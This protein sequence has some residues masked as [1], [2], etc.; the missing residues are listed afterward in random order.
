MKKISWL[1]ISDCHLTNLDKWESQGVLNALI[2]DVERF[3]KKN[4]MLLDFVFITGDLT[5]SG[6]KEE[7]EFFGRF[8]EKLSSVSKVNKERVYIV[9]GNHDYEINLQ[10]DNIKGLQVDAEKSLMD[11]KIARIF[12]KESESGFLDD[13]FKPSE[14][15]NLFIERSTAI[16]RKKNALYYTANITAKNDLPNVSII[17]FN[18]AF[19]GSHYGLL[20]RFQVNEALNEIEQEI[21]NGNIIIG[22]SHHPL[23][24]LY[25]KDKDALGKLV[26]NKLDFLLSGHVHQTEILGGTYS[27]CTEIR[28]RTSYDKKESHHQYGYCFVELDFDEMKG[29]AIFRVFSDAKGEFVQDSELASGDGMAVGIKE[30]Q[31]PNREIEMPTL[32]QEVFSHIEKQEKSLLEKKSPILPKII[33][34]KDIYYSKN[35]ALALFQNIYNIKVSEIAFVSQDILSDLKTQIEKR[36]NI[37]IVLTGPAGSGK[38]TLARLVYLRI[39]NECKRNCNIFPIYLDLRLS[40]ETDTIETLEKIV[41]PWNSLIEQMVFFIDSFDEF[42]TNNLHSGKIDKVVSNLKKLSSNKIA[43]FSIRDKFFEINHESI[44]SLFDSN[45]HIQLRPWCVDTQRDIISSFIRNYLAFINPTVSKRDL[46]STVDRAIETM[47]KSGFDFVPLYTIMFACVIHRSNGIRTMESRYSLYYQFV[48]EML[49][50]QGKDEQERADEIF[51]TSREA[52]KIYL[53]KVIDIKGTVKRER[54]EVFEGGLDIFFDKSHGKGESF[55]H[56][57]FFQFFVATYV[58]D[59]F[60]NRATDN[61]LSE[62]LSIIHTS[63][64]N[65]LSKGYIDMILNQ[66]ENLNSSKNYLEICEVTKNLESAFLSAQDKDYQIKNEIVYFLGR[67]SNKF[68]CD[69]LQKLYMKYEEKLNTIF[70]EYKT[71]PLIIRQWLMIFRTLSISL[72]KQGSKKAEE[73]YLNRL[74]NSRI[75]DDVNRGIHLEYYQDIEYEKR[76][77]FPHTDPEGS[78]VRW[79]KTFARL[80]KHILDICHEAANPYSHN[81]ESVLCNLYLFTIHSFVRDRFQRN[82]DRL[83]QENIEALAFL[84]VIE[85]II[86]D[87]MESC[88]LVINKYLFEKIYAMIDK[89]IEEFIQDTGS[90]LKLNDELMTQ[91]ND[92][93]KC[94]PINTEFERNHSRLIS[95]NKRK[96]STE[97]RYFATLYSLYDL[98]H[99]ERV[100]WKKKGLKSVESVADHTF[101]ALILGF[102]YKET[103]DLNREKLFELILIHDLCETITGDLIPNDKVSLSD[104][105]ISELS[106]IEIIAQGIGDSRVLN[107]FNEFIEGKTEEAKFARD[108]DIL[109]MLFQSQVYSSK[110]GIKFEDMYEYAEKGITSMYGKKI[111]DELKNVKRAKEKR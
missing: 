18:T 93:K 30:L 69:V 105:H 54:G 101:S 77:D 40:E 108:L 39:L 58:V 84:M 102:F 20:T 8:L 5:Y 23:D 111:L 42:V 1:H 91:I 27:K 19:L 110:Y 15:F 32:E 59:S 76:L 34:L 79:D 99:V 25:E 45:K 49:L 11:K 26:R 50:Q 22:L 98:K 9:Q 36:N 65:F 67:M 71:D 60:F 12:Q 14:S 52:W 104:K 4:K 90:Y 88:R 37:P 72:L 70:E 46:D 78:G 13:I 51:K 56:D 107:L 87:H 47:D 2:R 103:K 68:A 31:I 61:Q 80:K 3:L 75:E 97:G 100:G 16:H 86:S 33:S 6:K 81:K 38:T 85:D 66:K 7:F 95:Y 44:S 35:D 53:D 24:H 74:F 89:T 57:S 106:A 21:S 62:A 17:G 63:D 43:L 28:V 55:L 96:G 73:D 29:N 94:I 64:I 82:N 83:G 109:D 10:S 48:N 41:G 92:I